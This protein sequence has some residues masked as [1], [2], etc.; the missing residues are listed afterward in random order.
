MNQAN[1][2]AAKVA[3]V[4]G[5]ARRIGAAIVNKLHQANFKVVIHCHQS[6]TE[7]EVLATTLNKQ[8]PDSAYVVCSNLNSIKAVEEILTKTLNWAK[9]LDVLVN[10]AS[11][12]NRTDLTIVDEQEWNNLFDI[13][14]KFPFFLS[15]AARSQLAKN[16]GAI[17]N[18]TDIHGRMPL[19]GY[20]VYSQTKAALAMQTKALAREFAPEVR[21]NAIAPGAIAWPEHDN[22]L[23][24]ETQQ[25]IIAKTPLKRHGSPEFVAQALLGLVENPFITGQILN[26][27]GGRSIMS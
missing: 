22:V 7:A 19:K 16:H 11:V 13:N 5:S 3:L 21:V 4:T 18:I 1:K 17:I 8:R 9:R 23:N 24:I 27:D 15:L 12:F 2:Q 10:N 20:A 26:V 25:K 14:V 6:L